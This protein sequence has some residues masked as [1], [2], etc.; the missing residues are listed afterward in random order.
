ML[1]PVEARRR[2]RERPKRPARRLSTMQ[3][4]RAR[5]SRLRRPR[6]SRQSRSRPT[7]SWRLAPRGRARAQRPTHHQLRRALTRALKRAQTQTRRTVPKPKPKPRRALRFNLDTSRRMERSW[8][9]TN[10][11]MKRR[12]VRSMSSE[13]PPISWSWRLKRTLSSSRRSRTLMLS[14]SESWMSWCLV[15]S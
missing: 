11:S 12:M 7:L 9:S 3:R 2:R 6:L 1:K 4:L 8:P 10:T 15:V 5:S 14:P 13:R